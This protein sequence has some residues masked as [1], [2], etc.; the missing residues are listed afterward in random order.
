[1]IIWIIGL[2]GSGKT[3]LGLELAKQLR[4]IEKNTVLLDGDELREFFSHFPSDDPYTINNR[5]INAERM[6]ALCQLLDAQ[7][8]NVIC[9]TLSIFPDIRAD[10]RKRFK[11]YVEIF[12]DA[13]IE[14][15]R[16]RDIKGLYA[17]AA[18]GEMKNVVGEDIPFERPQHSDIVIDSSNSLVNIGTVATQVLTQIGIK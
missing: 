3:T 15:V 5:R 13:P 14:I 10:N 8:I 12:M 11:R 9:C 18:K 16:L 7:D 1:M 6:V 2:S 17:A 4:H